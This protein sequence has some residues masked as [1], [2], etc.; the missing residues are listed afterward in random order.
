M[1]QDA[2]CG[3]STRPEERAAAGDIKA[4]GSY[5]IGL[6]GLNRWTLTMPNRS[7]DADTEIVLDNLANGSGRSQQWTLVPFTGFTGSAG[8]W[9]IASA[10]TPQMCLSVPNYQQRLR[11]SS[12]LPSGRFDRQ[13]QAWRLI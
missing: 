11:Q 13:L 8:M 2:N 4:D 6:A 10:N 12:C 3:G 5:T 1:S 9:E 7:H